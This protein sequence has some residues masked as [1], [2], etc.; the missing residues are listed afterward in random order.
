MHL[1]TGVGRVGFPKVRNDDDAPMLSRD[2]DSS[3]ARGSVGFA[4]EIDT[5]KK[6]RTEVKMGHDFRVAIEK[7]VERKSMRNL[8]ST[9]KLFL[10]L[11]MHHHHHPV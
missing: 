2:G 3:W 10:S 11:A 7:Y 1:L 8:R 5:K 6:K 9:R 4:L